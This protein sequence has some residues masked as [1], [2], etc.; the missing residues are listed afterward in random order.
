MQSYLPTRA[1]PV[2]RFLE[3]GQEQTSFLE[4]HGGTSH[5]KFYPCFQENQIMLENKNSEKQAS[6][7]VLHDELPIVV[8]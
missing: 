4:I 6:Q 8:L 2:P 3:C 1:Q 7:N 5:D